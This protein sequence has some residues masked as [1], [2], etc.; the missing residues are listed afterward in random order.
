MFLPRITNAGTPMDRAE[1]EGKHRRTCHYTAVEESR[2]RFECTL[3]LDLRLFMSGSLAT[4]KG[5]H[6]FFVRKRSTC[7]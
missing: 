6:P 1:R 2:T 7:A 3:G 5:F 4:S